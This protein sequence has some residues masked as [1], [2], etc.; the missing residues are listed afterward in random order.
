MDNAT[1]ISGYSALLP[2]AKDSDTLIDRLK[3]GAC[4]NKTY[5]FETDETAMACGL[6][7]NK[8]TA[9]LAHGYDSVLNLLCDL[10]DQSLEKAMLGQHCLSGE[11]VRV[12]LTGL[13]PRVDV[14]DYA[15]FYDHND[16][17]DVKLSKSIL[18]LH[19][20]NLSQDKLAYGLAEKYRLK[21]MP[22]NLHATSN[23][24]L[25]AIHLGIQAIGSGDV[26][27]VLVINCSEIKTQDIYF[28]ESQS[29]LEGHVTQPFCEESQ[30]V[31][32]SEG[33]STLLL[34]SSRHRNAR[35]VQG[36][37]KLTS[38]YAQVSAG[39]NHDSTQL[40]SSLLK[41]MNKAMAQVNVTNEA[42]CAI[43][44]HAN[45]SEGSDKAESQ[46]LSLLLGSGTVP[47]LA[48]KGQIGYVTTG[49]GLVDLIIGHHL[50]EHG[51][52]L[53]PVGSEV[54]RANIAQHVL[55]NCGVVKHNKKHLLKLGLGVDGSIIGMVMSKSHSDK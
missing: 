12:Y 10:I 17:E 55:L 33:F 42:L 52:L 53:S 44:P 24:S 15:S 54:I 28:L 1:I 13:G 18:N 20:S 45:G 36:G 46:A 47:I 32:P 2:F 11:N 25:S 3:Q 14:Q 35:Q 26:D 27:L 8:L 22:P 39:R 6:K 34:E 49:S 40:T 29:M 19:A 31:L 30:C 43:I 51:E 7:S 50:L 48:Y 5:W 9:R 41:V 38:Y 37:I 16:I 4:V 21:L 23:S